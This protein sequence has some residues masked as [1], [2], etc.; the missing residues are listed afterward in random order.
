MRG[1]LEQMLGYRMVYAGAVLEGPDACLDP[2]DVI[3]F[4]GVGQTNTKIFY[5]TDSYDIGKVR[6][7]RLL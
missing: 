7:P 2:E 1:T 5:G 4:Y 3:G 6:A